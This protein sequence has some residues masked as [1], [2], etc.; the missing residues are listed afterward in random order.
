MQVNDPNDLDFIIKHY[1]KMFKRIII[2]FS[3]VILCAAYF[4]YTL[5]LITQPNY[6]ASSESGVLKKLSSFERQE[7]QRMIL[8]R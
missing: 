5:T 6:Y 1:R 7:V 2:L 4:Y 8:G 3:L